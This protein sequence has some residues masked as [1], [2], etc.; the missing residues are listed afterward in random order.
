MTKAIDDKLRELFETTPK[1]IS[2]GFGKKSINGQF[3]DNEAIVFLV[4]KKLTLDELS[5]DQILPT[6]VEIDGIT[7]KTD[8]VESGPIVPTATRTYVYPEQ[9]QGGFV[10]NPGNRS[11]VGY[12]GPIVLDA[13]TNAIVGLTANHLIVQN[14]FYTNERIGNNTVAVNA[15]NDSAYMYNPYD[16]SARDPK[17]YLGK[18]L[19]YVPLS[20]VNYNQVDAALI[21]LDPKIVNLR[22]GY[23][24]SY[25]ILAI[26]PGKPPRFATTQ[27]IN[28]LILL[29]IPVFSCLFNQQVELA[30]FL[31]NA[32]VNIDDLPN[33]GSKVSAPFSNMLVV[34]GPPGQ[35]RPGDSGA[36]VV[37]RLP[38]GEWL[39]VGIVTGANSTGTI[40]YI[41]RIDE[42]APQLSVK[43]WD[44]TY[45][46]F[47]DMN[48]VQIRA[49]YNTSGQKTINCN[50][51][52]YWQIG[53]G[54]NTN[55]C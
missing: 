55:Y 18:V 28:N 3:T 1:E 42:I 46:P 43:A 2:V 17:G 27:E 15:L 51:K 8:V 9:V 53:S 33:N 13:E 32:Y 21:A 49:T 26:P 35:I 44:G 4:P 11:T 30:P 10:I 47:I 38:S 20:M 29:E 5:K 19:K 34:T 14:G 7:Y 48:S 45:Q 52:R 37:T 24:S 40:G 50:G 36:P 54:N 25:N 22:A 41:S 23:Y 39:I 6:V 16:P 31:I 12:L